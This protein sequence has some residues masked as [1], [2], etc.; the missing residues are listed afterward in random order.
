MVA[1]PGVGAGL[2]GAGTGGRLGVAGVSA[3]GRPEGRTRRCGRE[4]RRGVGAA[5]APSATILPPRRCLAGP[6]EVDDDARAARPDRRPKR[7]EAT[8]LDGL[9]R[10]RWRPELDF[11]RPSGDRREKVDLRQ[12]DDDA[13]GIGE[14]IGGGR[15]GRGEIEESSS[16]PSA[17]APRAQRWSRSRPCGHGSQTMRGACRRHEP[18]SQRPESAARPVTARRAR[19]Q[20]EA[21]C[22]PCDPSPAPVRSERPCEA[23]GLRRAG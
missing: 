15:D 23:K 18:A 4:R 16:A 3:R 17:H 21:R 8:R 5:D 10:R 13:V 19:R 20:D 22:E 7:Y 14:D 1:R 2:T 11:E 9:A 12:V 6:G